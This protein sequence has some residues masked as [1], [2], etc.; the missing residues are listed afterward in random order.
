MQIRIPFALHDEISL[1]D[2][3]NSKIY[4]SKVATN[5]GLPEQHIVTYEIFEQ[6]PEK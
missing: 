5:E 1:K 6:N 4:I 3:G 2:V